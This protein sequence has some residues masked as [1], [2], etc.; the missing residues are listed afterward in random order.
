MRFEIE[1]PK[2]RS[3]HAWYGFDHAVGFFVTVEKDDEPVA[4]YDAVTK[5]YDIAKPLLGALRFMAQA[6]FFEADD[7]EAALLALE[8]DERTTGGTKIA[9][10]VITNFKA[11]ADS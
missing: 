7:I 1:H 5:G 10:D 4:I 8:R 9:A 11:A 3:R 2:D 6:G